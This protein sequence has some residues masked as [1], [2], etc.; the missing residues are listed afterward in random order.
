[1]KLCFP[2]ISKIVLQKGIKDKEL[3]EYLYLLKTQHLI[4]TQ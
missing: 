3:N 4:A 1:M 2:Y